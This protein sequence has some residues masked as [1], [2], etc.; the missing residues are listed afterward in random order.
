MDLETLL[1]VDRSRLRL[2]GGLPGGGGGGG[3]RR[4]ARKP[5]EISMPA[6]DPDA[7]PPMTL[8]A[9]GKKLGAC[10]GPWAG[11]G[12][13]GWTRPWQR[14]LSSSLRMTK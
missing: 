4:E 8:G 5:P 3:A 12:P 1:G 14:S 2:G 6:P 11:G 7:R 10:G 13:R 9:E